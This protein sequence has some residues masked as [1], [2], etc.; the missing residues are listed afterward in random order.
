M[1]GNAGSKALSRI[2]VDRNSAL[3][4]AHRLLRQ[5]LVDT[6]STIARPALAEVHWRRDAAV[7][8]A[9]LPLSYPLDRALHSCV[10]R[11]SVNAIF[12]TARLPVPLLADTDTAAAMHHHAAV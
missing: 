4:A 10:Y 2:F 1:R 7:A 12:A 11:S 9:T 8:C 3:W 6:R 5:R